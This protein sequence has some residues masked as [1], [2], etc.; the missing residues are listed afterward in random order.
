MSVQ[1]MNHFTVL[2]DD[3]E[4]T[5]KFYCDL[6]GFEVRNDVG[7]GAMRWLTVGPV[8]QPGTSIVLNPPAAN[9]GRPRSWTVTDS[10]QPVRAGGGL[11]LTGAAGLLAEFRRELADSQFDFGDAEI[12]RERAMNP[13]GDLLHHVVAFGR[14]AQ[15]D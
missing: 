5:R 2:S 3:L 6:L 10:K 12:M 11:S 13:L 9:P 7:Q 14:L 1:A 8:D 4:A 15:R